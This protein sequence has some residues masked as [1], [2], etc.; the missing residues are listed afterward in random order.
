MKNI[1]EIR[2][3][4]LKGMGDVAITLSDIETVGNLLSPELSLAYDG[5]AGEWV[6]EDG[7]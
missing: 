1:I 4:P 2:G 5:D 7:E 3:E 6:L